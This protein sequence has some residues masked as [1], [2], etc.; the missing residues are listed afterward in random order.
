[1]MILKM[2]LRLTQKQI[3]SKNLNLTIEDVEKDVIPVSSNKRQS[4]LGLYTTFPWGYRG[5]NMIHYYLIA[6][7]H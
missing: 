6:K 1:M 3:K 7:K 5:K 2:Q 4:F